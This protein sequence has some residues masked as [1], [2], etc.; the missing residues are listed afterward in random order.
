[1]TNTPEKEQ[2]DEG[3]G[4]LPTKRRRFQYSL[5]SLL[6]VITVLCIWFAYIANEARKQK[7][8]VA[9]IQEMEGW[10]RHDY[11]FDEDGKNIKD[12]QP[13]GP[14][15]LREWI[16]IDYFCDV[17][18][19]N[20]IGAQVKDLSPLEKLP[21]LEV[22]SLSYTQVSDLS[23]LINLAKLK[24]LLV[25]NS[26]VNDLSPLAGLTK[27]E[28]LYLLQIPVSDLTPLKNLTNLKLLMIWQSQVADL[29]PLAGLTNLE[30]LDLWDA[31]VKDISPL[32]GLTE[33]IWLNLVGT[34]VTDLTSLENLT[35]LKNLSLGNTP[36]SKE[37][38]QKLQIALPNCKIS[39]DGE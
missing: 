9:Q 23:P 20:L 35:N 18:W 3:K 34:Q 26:Q 2:D 11:E 12:A 1:M 17:T 36:V 28:S 24:F 31:P 16:G 32:K 33:L 13:P 7:N 39:W 27:L 21:N 22:L 14:D 25:G 30:R 10:V 37:E 29:T 38:V 5:R 6:L 4:E 19:I 15:W 8:A